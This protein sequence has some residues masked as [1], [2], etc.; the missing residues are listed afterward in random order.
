MLELAASIQVSPSSTYGDYTSSTSPDI[1][2]LNRYR[3]K[4]PMSLEMLETADE[5]ALSSLDE[6]ARSLSKSAEFTEQKQKQAESSRSMAFRKAVE[7]ARITQLPK[8]PS[9]TALSAA[10]S[11]SNTSFNPV[12]I[13]QNRS[14]RADS[15]LSPP[16]DTWVTNPL[17]QYGSSNIRHSSGWYESSLDGHDIGV[18]KRDNFESQPIDIDLVAAQHNANNNSRQFSAS[19]HT[20]A[21]KFPFDH[22]E[23]PHRISERKVDS[24]YLKKQE[25]NLAKH[26]RKKRNADEYVG[27]ISGR[28][29]HSSSSHGHHSTGDGLW[30]DHAV[31]PST[32]FIHPSQSRQQNP[33]SLSLNSGV[34][35]PIDTRRLQIRPHGP[36]AALPRYSTNTPRYRSP[37]ADTHSSFNPYHT[38]TAS[39]PSRRKNSASIAVQTDALHTVR[40]STLV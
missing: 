22:E 8:I 23:L 37:P 9:S 34:N 26:S 40:D 29:K 1:P 32:N 25:E 36:S 31:H 10:L 16:A 15:D 33:H 2:V 12:V 38:N 35:D 20:R 30:E 3:F 17:Q 27:E 14:V 21:S 4:R 24:A 19:L 7:D 28:S 13:S 6:V 11:A 18:I 5:S 39:S